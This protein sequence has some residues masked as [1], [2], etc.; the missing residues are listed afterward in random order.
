MNG[1]DLYKQKCAMICTQV[2]AITNEICVP[3]SNFS[4]G[5]AFTSTITNVGNRLLCQQRAI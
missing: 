1:T 2:V 4:R 3:T 5:H